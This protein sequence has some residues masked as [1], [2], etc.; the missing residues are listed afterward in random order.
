MREAWKTR[1]SFGWWKT[2]CTAPLQMFRSGDS[3]RRRF[4][5]VQTLHRPPPRIHDIP[6]PCLQTPPPDSTK[7]QSQRAYKTWDRQT[8]RCLCSSLLLLFNRDSFPFSV[9]ILLSN[10]FCRN[11]V[12][13]VLFLPFTWCD[14]ASTRS[15][16]K[17]PIFIV[18]IHKCPHCRI[19]SMPYAHSCVFSTKCRFQPE[20]Q[21]VRFRQRE[22]GSIRQLPLPPAQDNRPSRQEKAVEYQRCSIAYRRLEDD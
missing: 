12:S 22:T 3:H 11:D 5:R 18:Y 8:S 16:Y 2:P 14:F 19:D 17:K 20:V 9:S 6:F 21:H 4:Q 7:C 1:W 15:I 13:S 10:E